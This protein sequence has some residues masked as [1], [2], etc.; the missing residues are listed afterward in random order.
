MCHCCGS[1]TIFFLRFYYLT[2]GFSLTARYSLLYSDYSYVG[3]DK[4]SFDSLTAT[5]GLKAT[6]DIP[7]SLVLLTATSSMSLNVVKGGGHS[8]IESNG[9][10]K[11]PI[12]PR[13]VLGPIRFINHDCDPNCQVGQWIFIKC[14]L[15]F[16]SFYQ[17]QTLMPSPSC[18]FDQYPMGNLLRYDTHKRVTMSKVLHVSA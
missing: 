17:L 18:L 14:L 6:R 12:G 2:F 9:R 11:G 5:G 13:L 16:Y 15:I 8:V 1:E 10:Q 4:I 3:I 7:A